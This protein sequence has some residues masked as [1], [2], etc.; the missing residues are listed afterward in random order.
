MGWAKRDPAVLANLQTGYPRFFVHLLVRRL[1]DSIKQWISSRPRTTLGSRLAEIKSTSYSV[2]LFPNQAMASACRNFLL[3]ECDKDD[4]AERVQPV[5]IVGCGD[6]TIMHG[7]YSG[8]SASPGN[9]VYVVMYPDALEPG[10]KAF[11]Q[12]TGYG[13]SSRFART[14]L[15][16][17]T[18]VG[19]NGRTEND[20]RVPTEKAKKAALAIR[21]RIAASHTSIE[22]PVCAHD[23]FLYQSGMTAITQTALMI[24]NSLQSEKKWQLRVAVFGYVDLPS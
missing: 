9:V 11:W 7:E 10:A 4:D 8:R 19:E 20:Y 16:V 23:V 17:A 12:H 3:K 6:L 14:W 24:K 13:I 1:E 5:A 2:K 18:F 15:D 21:T 22:N